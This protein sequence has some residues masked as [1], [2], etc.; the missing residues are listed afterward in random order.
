MTKTRENNIKKYILGSIFIILIYVV[1]TNINTIIYIL[2]A[3]IVVVM[4]IVLLWIINFFGKINQK[5]Y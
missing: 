5:R 4:F 3:A 2:Q 1:L